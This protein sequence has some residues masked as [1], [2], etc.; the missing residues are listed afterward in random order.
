[1]IKRRTQTAVEAVTAA[2][3]SYV[4]L[5]QMDKFDSVLLDLFAILVIVLSVLA[6]SRLLFGKRDIQA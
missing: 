5:I 4:A 1:M 6:A 3:L 2:V